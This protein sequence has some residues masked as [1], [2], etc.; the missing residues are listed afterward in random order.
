MHDF[1][2]KFFASSPESRTVNDN[3]LSFK[4]A[5]SSSITKHVPTKFVKSSDKRPVWLTRSV[6]RSIKHRDAA[7]KLAKKSGLL[8]DRDKYRKLR[9]E[10]SK[11]VEQAY[12]TDLNKV[13]GN[14]KEDRRGYYRS[15]KSKR[16]ESIGIPPLKVNKDQIFSDND[17]ANCL[18]NYFSSVFTNKLV[19]RYANVHCYCSWCF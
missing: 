10:T 12:R 11:L 4:D 18:N 19:S 16:R 9:N 6:R 1:Q 17:K 13:I 3:W 8:N 7:A 15:I 14:L 2:S 5:L